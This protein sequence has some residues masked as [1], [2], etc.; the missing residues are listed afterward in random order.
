MYCGVQNNSAIYMVALF[1]EFFE[2]EVVME[3]VIIF[4]R[5]L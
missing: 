2:V 3:R 1:D 5:I 4:G